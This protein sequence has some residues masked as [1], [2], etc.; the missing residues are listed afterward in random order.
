ERRKDLQNQLRLLL[1]A[2]KCQ[3]NDQLLQQQLQQQQQQQ[4]Q[5]PPVNGCQLPQCAMMKQTLKHMME[6]KDGKTCKA[7]KCATLRQI[8]THWKNCNRD[9]CMFC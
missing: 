1:H 9:E 7:P 4:Q 6:C 8:I 5:H 2:H 3:Q